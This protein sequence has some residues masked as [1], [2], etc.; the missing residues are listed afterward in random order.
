MEK[1]EGEQEKGEGAWLCS[2]LSVDRCLP[3]M[4]VPVSV[5]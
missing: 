5:M 4:E 2:L 3:V 1:G